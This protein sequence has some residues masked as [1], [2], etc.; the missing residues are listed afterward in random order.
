LFYTKI[1]DEEWFNEYDSLHYSLENK[2][3]S[4]NRSQIKQ[5]KEKSEWRTDYIIR[6]LEEKYGINK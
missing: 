6:E 2:L 5:L 3:I 4:Y 1:I